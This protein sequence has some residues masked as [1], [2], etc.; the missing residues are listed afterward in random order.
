MATTK[1]KENI[2]KGTTHQQ[3]Q[4]GIPLS[5]SPNKGR[6]PKGGDHAIESSKN[7]YAA[8]ENI[9]VEMVESK[10]EDITSQNRAHPKEE[11][12]PLVTQ[13]ETKISNHGDPTPS[14]IPTRATFG[15]PVILEEEIQEES[16]EELEIEVS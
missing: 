12:D 1:M 15:I 3:D 2:R 16:R 14:K 9:E 11:I 10:E 4:G 7:K 5:S 6:T 13:K 8:L